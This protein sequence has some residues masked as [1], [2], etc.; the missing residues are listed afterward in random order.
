MTCRNQA[1]K[2]QVFKS[3]K[4]CKVEGRDQR[5]AMCDVPVLVLGRVLWPKRELQ[6]PGTTFLV[7]AKTQA[8]LLPA[9]P[10]PSPS[11]SSSPK[12]FLGS[13]FPSHHHLSHPPCE[14]LQGGIVFYR[15]IPLFSHIIPP[16]SLLLRDFASTRTEIYI[17]TLLLLIAKTLGRARDFRHGRCQGRP[18]GSPAITH[19]HTLSTIEF[20]RR[21]T[22]RI[23]R[24]R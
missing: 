14:K 2:V 23:P 7:Q 15:P 1:D 11:E 10:L 16:V 12:N 21:S 22:T 3:C 17:S 18:L 9:H 19:H 24:V 20:L 13:A 5:C 6:G 4:V 8:A